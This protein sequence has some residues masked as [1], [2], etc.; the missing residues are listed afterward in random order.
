MRSRY[1]MAD[2]MYVQYHWECSC[3]W[4]LDLDPGTVPFL[5]TLRC[6]RCP[7]LARAVSRFAFYPF[8]KLTI[9]A[10][11]PKEVANEVVGL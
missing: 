4:S 9:S 6:P 11:I 2:E 1:A 8:Q 3:G 5:K 10:T 7:G